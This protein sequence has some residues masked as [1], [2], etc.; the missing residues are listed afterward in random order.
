MDAKQKGKLERYFKNS[1]RFLWGLGPGN[2][3]E[4]YRWLMGKGL[5][6][7][8]GSYGHV[9]RQLLENPGIDKLLRNIIIPRVKKLFTE[10]AIDFLRSCWNAGTR[11]DISFLKLY[12]IKYATPFLEVNIQYDYV[13]RWG[14]LAGL[15]FEEIEKLQQEL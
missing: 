13:E 2:Q 6:F 7:N 5:T 8:A 3:K 11:P 15:W 10:K 4:N 12:N 9:T 1:E 14:E